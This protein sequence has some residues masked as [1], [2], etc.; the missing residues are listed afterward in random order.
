[1]EKLMIVCSAA[2]LAVAMVALPAYAAKPVCTDGDNDTYSPE[3]KSC[4][5]VDCDDA[6]AAI[7]PGA[8]EV[9]DDGVDNDCDGDIDAA[10]ADCG[11]GC[12]V[13]ENP[14]MSCSDGIDNDCDGAIDG[15]DPDC[16]TCTP[17]PGEETQELTCDDMIDNDCDGATDGADSDCQASS[18][19]DVIVMAS[20]DLGMHCACPG[21]EY[22]L[23]LPPFNTLRAQVIERGGSSPVVLSDD[24]DIRVTYNI[25]EN[26]DDSLKA[27]PYYQDWIIN[28]P[29]YGFGQA[30]DSTDGKIQGLLG[31]KLDGEMEAQAEG[32][33]EVVGVPAFPEA[34]D[35][36]C[37]N[38]P[39][40]PAC[41]R[42]IMTD[43]LGGPNRNPYLTGHIEVYDQATDESLAETDITVPVAFG[44][45]CGCHLQVT[46][47]YKQ[48]SDPQP[49]D[50]FLLMG[51]LHER[52]SGIDI[53]QLDP[54]GDGTVG[55]VRCSVCHWDPAMGETNPYDGLPKT[56]DYDGELR[57]ASGY[58]DGNGADL[59]VSQYTFSDV[60]H[61]WH[62]QNPAVIAYDQDLATDC[63]QCHPGNGVDCYRGHHTNKTLGRGQDSHPVWC[64]DCH[65]DLN[66]RVAEGQ[67]ENPWSEDTLP[68]CQQCHSA[69][70][71]NGVLTHTFGGSFL[72]SMSHKNDKILCSTCHG[73]P[74]ALNPST[75]AKDNQQN[76]G[77]QEVYVGT[78]QGAHA[79]GVCKVCHTNK[80]DSYSK[81]AH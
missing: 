69:T 20:N 70:G 7:N 40:D 11:G 38:N 48:L 27:D 19:R 14:E 59:P 44:G 30:I 64:T 65:G 39:D 75:L 74:H 34:P 21:A 17:T 12:T 24:T 10:D 29:K 50:S 31:A 15:A 9:C 36:F 63:Y 28:M 54:D 52:D 77:L 61:R 78:E 51:E 41:E 81:P 67:L 79:I 62:V 57:A 80:K 73:S 5:P 42:F 47:D 71:E 25:V 53:A 55:P 60:L 35:T 32:W 43:P 56:V 26:T 1:M 66:Q 58:V 45:C 72:K 13:T 18:S 3:G 4:G 6:V 46:A 2:M 16:T 22:F 8:T 49:E 23:L 33:W 37:E 68:K 76:I